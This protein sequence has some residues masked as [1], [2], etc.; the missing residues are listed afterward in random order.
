[1]QTGVSIDADAVEKIEFTDHARPIVSIDG[2]PDVAMYGEEPFLTVSG[3][4]RHPP[5]RHL[6]TVDAGAVSFVANGADVMRPGIVE[7]DPTIEAGDLVCVREE[8]HGKVLAVGRAL[9]D[10]SSMLGDSGRVIETVHHV[11]DALYALEL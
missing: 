4:N 5:D 8:T 9:T 7:A 3:A 1:M 10:G 11:G 6:V 2:H